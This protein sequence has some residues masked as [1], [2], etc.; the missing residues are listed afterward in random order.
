MMT[1]ADWLRST[2]EE[3]GMSQREAARRLE[4]DDRTMRYWCSGQMPIPKVI[5]LAI[6]T[7]SEEPPEGV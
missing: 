5:K 4:V 6:E 1:E 3:L 2:L 7:L